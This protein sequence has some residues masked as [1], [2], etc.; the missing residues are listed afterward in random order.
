M[1]SVRAIPNMIVLYSNFFSIAAKW[2]IGGV[3]DPSRVFGPFVHNSRPAT[4]IQ[5]ERFRFAIRL[6]ACP[7]NSLDQTERNSRIRIRHRHRTCTHERAYIC[8]ERTCVA[9]CQPHF[10]DEIGSDNNRNVN[11]NIYLCMPNCGKEVI[12][13]Q[14]TS[15]NKLK[16]AFDNV[17]A[18]LQDRRSLRANVMNCNGNWYMTYIRVHTVVALE[19]FLHNASHNYACMERSNNKRWP[20]CRAT[21]RNGWRI[22]IAVRIRHCRKYIWIISHI[23]PYRNS[24]IFLPFHEALFYIHKGEH[25]HDTRQSFMCA[26]INQSAIFAARTRNSDLHKEIHSYFSVLREFGYYLLLLADH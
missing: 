1:K 3:G 25:V 13:F 16:L 9:H 10:H 14:Q 11:N 20:P 23:I 5:F 4:R 8:R 12:R 2:T 7:R 18:G 15:N 26:C 6:S 17:A 19:G 22:F 24:Y 21:K